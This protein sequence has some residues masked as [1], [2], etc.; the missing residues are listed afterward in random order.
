MC[1]HRTGF[2]WVS[3]AELALGWVTVNDTLII[4]AR[5]GGRWSHWYAHACISSSANSDCAGLPRSPLVKRCIIQDLYLCRNL[6]LT[7]TILNYRWNRQYVGKWAARQ[8]N[9]DHVR[10]THGRWAVLGMDI[11]LLDL[12][13]S[14]S[15]VEA[16]LES[17]LGFWRITKIPNPKANLTPQGPWSE[18]QTPTTI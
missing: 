16:V 8:V 17:F 4:S 18:P 13:P 12:G 5:V 2:T 10:P 15:R 9:T 6:T 7:I 3:I 1:P 11:Y 14:V